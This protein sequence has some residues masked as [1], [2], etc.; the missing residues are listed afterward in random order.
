[1]ATSSAGESADSILKR[2]A[3]RR[4]IGAIALVLAAV[5]ALPM[6]FDDEKRPLDQDVSIQ[7][8]S[9][10]VVTI[11]PPAAPGVKPKTVEP[12]EPAIAT[13]A[14]AKD[15][16]LTEPKP[17]PE[18]ARVS[19]AG[20][21]SIKETAKTS[22]SPD[23][24]A[25][26]VAAGKENS[27]ADPGSATKAATKEA[28]GRTSTAPESGPMAKTDSNGE[29]SRVREILAGHAAPANKSAGGF[30]VQIGAFAADD[31][32]RESRDKLGVAGFSTYT[33]KLATSGG[34]A[35]R[36]RAGPFSSRDAAEAARDKI[37]ALGFPGA[38]VVAQ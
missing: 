13:G 32:V 12:R 2:R 16:A 10:D 14:A 36:V 7:I 6:I 15:R 19:A 25:A 38:A 22:V 27:R 35:T 5:I 33:E 8:P 1:M 26:V 3:R 34:A 21:E 11:R 31:K 37:R 9:Q 28:A 30:A 17:D 20:K 23:P 29:A 4:L 24:R 18:S